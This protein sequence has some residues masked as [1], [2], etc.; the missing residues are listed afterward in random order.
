MLAHL[1]AMG[2]ATRVKLLSFAYVAPPAA[3]ATALQLQGSERTQHSLRVRYMDDAPFSLLS[4]Y[5]PE[6][7][8]VTYSK[9]D[10]VATPLLYVVWAGSRYSLRPVLDPSPRQPALGGRVV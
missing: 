1:V 9:S 4:T 6:R 10:L 7:I 2:R 3:V 8:G 5:V